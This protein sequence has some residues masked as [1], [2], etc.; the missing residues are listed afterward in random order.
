MLQAVQHPRH[1]LFLPDFFEGH[2]HAW[3]MFEDVFGNI[4]RE[5]T[6]KIEGRWEEETFIL[7]ERFQF[8]DGHEDRRIWRLRYHK[9][10]QFVAECPETIAPGIGRSVENGCTLS[11]R[12][13][14]AVGNRRIIVNFNDVFR[15]ID[16]NTMLNRAKVSKWGLPVGQVIVAFKRAPDGQ[17][18]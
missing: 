14:L 11:Y 18:F 3:G 17:A 15:L 5:F 16:E 2:S 7:D 6:V 4:K 8:S 9:D 12:F 13:R 1:N 10:G